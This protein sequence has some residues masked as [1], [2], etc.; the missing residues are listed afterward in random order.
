MDSGGVPSAKRMPSVTNSPKS[1]IHP[2]K[3]EVHRPG[4]LLVPPLLGPG[5]VQSMA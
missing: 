2:S 5:L 4:E 1:C 3:P